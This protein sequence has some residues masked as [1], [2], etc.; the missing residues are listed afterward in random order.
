MIQRRALT[1]TSCKNQR[2]VQMD[3]VIP[4]FIVVYLLGSQGHIRQLSTILELEHV[5]RPN[6]PAC[7]IHRSKVVADLLFSSKK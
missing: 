5:E 4:K 7:P 6:A 1:G 3:M 2:L